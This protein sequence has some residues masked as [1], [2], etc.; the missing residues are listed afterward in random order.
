MRGEEK[1]D[2]PRQKE[3]DSTV[4]GG[5]S[6]ISLSQVLGAAAMAGLRT[7]ADPEPWPGTAP[8]DQPQSLS[9]PG[10]GHPMGLGSGDRRLTC[11]FQAQNSLEESQCQGGHR[12]GMEEHCP[13]PTQ[14]KFPVGLPGWQVA[15]FCHDFLGHVQDGSSVRD[16]GQWPPT[17]IP[18]HTQTSPPHHSPLIS[19][20]FSLSHPKER[21]PYLLPSLLSPGWHVPQLL[22]T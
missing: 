9:G 19:Q 4:P 22:T 8:H 7:A 14:P 10:L 6:R 3:V 5:S 1:P 13:L 12:S 18:L 11:D 16:E 20:V 17:P 15:V 2:L 21:A